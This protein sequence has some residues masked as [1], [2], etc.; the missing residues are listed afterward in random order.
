[1]TSVI[2]IIIITSFAMALFNLCS[3]APYK[4]N[5]QQLNENV[6][7]YTELSFISLLSTAGRNCHVSERPLNEQVVNSIRCG[8]MMNGSL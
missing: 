8:L 7:M 4:R 3:A 1:M 2:I 6:V 5:T